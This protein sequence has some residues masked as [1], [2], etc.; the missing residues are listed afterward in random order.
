[1]ANVP[2]RVHQDIMLT[3]QMFIEAREEVILLPAKT[4]YEQDDGG[5]VTSS[6]RRVVFSP[7]LP[8]KIGECRAEW[9]ILRDIAIAAHPERAHL[10]GCE[11]GWR[12]REE[13]ARV[14]PLYE[15]VQHLRKIGDAFQYGG[16]HL[17]A[18]GVFPTDDGKAHLSAPP[19]P[20]GHEQGRFRVGIR[21][22]CQ[23]DA[24]VYAEIDPLTGADRD[25]IF[26]ADADAVRL[27]LENGERIA[28]VNGRGRYEG[29]VFLADIAPGNL[30]VMWPEG[31]SIIRR[32]AAVAS[33][34][35]LDY[36]AEVRVEPVS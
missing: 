16:A 9:K 8:R 13:I 24:P 18:G 31:N 34:G 25:A 17:C 26:M 30:Q 4:R 36:P 23:I 27:G 15:G 32:R 12:M 29:R 33:G 7:E 1:M 28:L 6:E 21:R 11:T 10:F 35:A 14:V 2:L 5:T 3:G 22:G 19:L 20:A